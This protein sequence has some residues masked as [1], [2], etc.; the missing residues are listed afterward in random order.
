MFQSSYPSA[1]T[2]DKGTRGV[3]RKVTTKMNSTLSNTF[4]REEVEQALRQIASLKSLGP[5]GFN[6]GFCQINWHIMSNE[7]TSTILKLQLFLNFLMRVA[8]INFFI[9]FTYIILISETKN[10]VKASNFRPISLCNMIYKIVSKLL[11][12][13]LKKI[14]LAIISKS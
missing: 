1:Q 11:A 7:V 12:N 14:L 8:F 2:L 3:G 4:T 9:N 6:L 5:N 13:R 10:H